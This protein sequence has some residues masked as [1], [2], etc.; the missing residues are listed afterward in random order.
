MSELINKNDNRAA[1]RWKL[2]ASVSAVALIASVTNA[3]AGDADH[4]LFWIEF[5]V[6]AD[7]ITGLG[8][9]F[10]PDFT[11]LSPTPTPYG[12][13]NSP[14][15][16]QKPPRYTFGGEAS[17][18]FQPEDS[19]WKFSAGIKYG[20]SNNKRDRHNQTNATVKFPNPAYEHLAALYPSYLPYYTSIRP[21]YTKYAGKF[22]GT[23]IAQSE[24][25]LV[26]DFQAGKD[27]GLGMFGHGGT[28]T[29]SAGVRVARFQFHSDVLVHARPDAGFYKKVFPNPFGVGPHAYYTIYNAQW[30]S[31]YLRA[32]AERSFNGIGPSL[33][34]NASVPLAGNPQNGELELD[35]GINGSFLFGKQ[36]AKIHHH[37]TGR[38]FMSK[39][40]HSF[41]T[42]AGGHHHDHYQPL[43]DNNGGRDQSHSVTVPNLGAVI[44]LSYRIENTK[45]SIGYRSDY[46]FGAMDGGIDAAKKTTLGFNG[47][48]ASVSIGLGD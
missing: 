44:G 12:N 23:T 3:A 38:Y 10:T 48:Y 33:S 16:L 31:Y 27:V 6:D 37:T 2:M 19:D 9:P 47:L 40:Y 32:S 8:Q 41:T 30:P 7:A 28:S 17:L 20:R 5:G 46:F 22:V 34:W 25:H 26:L 45:V 35:W 21:T 43:Y 13:G 24:R 18:T 14:I 29:L 11:R 39:Y 42:P 4:P 36:K 15:E 1:I